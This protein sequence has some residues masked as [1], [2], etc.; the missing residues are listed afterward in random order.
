MT[1]YIPGNP[2]TIVQNMPGAGSAV[3]ANYTYSA[4]KPDGLSVVRYE[5]RAFYRSALAREGSAI[6]LVEIRLGLAAPRRRNRCCPCGRRRLIKPSMMFAMRRRRRNAAP[7]APETR[8]TMFPSCSRKPS[9][10]NLPSSPDT[11]GGADIELAVERGE[12]KPRHQH[13]G[14]FRTRGYHT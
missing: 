12:M 10:Q 3:A 13:T 1:K 5:R 6:R 14:L 8:V 2:Q 4:A 9:A 11:P 7:P